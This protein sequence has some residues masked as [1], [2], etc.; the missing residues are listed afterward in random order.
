M[1][2]TFGTKISSKA[3]HPIVKRD[4]PNTLASLSCQISSKKIGERQSR[5]NADGQCCQSGSGWVSVAYFL[6]VQNVWQRGVPRRLSQIECGSL[7]N[8]YPLPRVDKCIN[9]HGTVNLFS[10]LVTTSNYL[11]FKLWVDKTALVTHSDLYKYTRMPFR[12]KNARATFQRATDISQ[13]PVKEQ[14]TLVYIYNV[15][16]FFESS[17]EHLNQVEFV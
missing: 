5:L 4:W 10:V 17:E 13:A 14:H 7:E 11:Q 1:G 15:V 16:I 6:F 12:L 9:Y 2:R 3:P 8:S